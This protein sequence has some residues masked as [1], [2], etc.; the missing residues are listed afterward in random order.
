[1]AQPEKRT[2]DV[3][4]WSRNALGGKGMSADSH[5]KECWAKWKLVKW[6]TANIER[7]STTLRNLA[8]V[9]QISVTKIENIIKKG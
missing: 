2:L 3:G 6:Q 4:R 8:D 9:I 1:M 5:T 7:P